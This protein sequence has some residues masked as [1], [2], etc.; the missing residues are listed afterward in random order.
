MVNIRYYLVRDRKFINEI[1]IY[2]SKLIGAYSRWSKFFKKTDP[3]RSR[4]YERLIELIKRQRKNIIARYKDELSNISNIR[5]EEELR[6]TLLNFAI[7]EERTFRGIQAY[8][9]RDF[10]ERIS[11]INRLIKLRKQILFKIEKLK[12]P[13]VK[14][15]PFIY[16]YTFVATRDVERIK[17]KPDGTPLVDKA[18]NIIKEKLKRKIEVHFESTAILTSDIQTKIEEITRLLVNKYNY[19][20]IYEEPNILKKP[21]SW[22]IEKS[23]PEPKQIETEFHIYDHTYKTM[24]IK[25]KR[26]LP[27][28]WWEES[29]EEIVKMII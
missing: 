24:R 14:I 23:I 22:R 8:I 15:T 28:K 10:P 17:R 25:I 19:D 18:G 2:Y 1:D 6:E 11:F 29:E 7:R 3:K 4:E 5:D 12:I 16:V 27:T 21:H 13:I 9:R 20:F 26:N